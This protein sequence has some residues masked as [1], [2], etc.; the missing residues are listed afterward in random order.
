LVVAIGVH[1]RLANEFAVFGGEGD[2]V[3]ERVEIDPL[4]SIAPADV[5]VTQLAEVVS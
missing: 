5:E 3:V 1:P 2:D 4:T